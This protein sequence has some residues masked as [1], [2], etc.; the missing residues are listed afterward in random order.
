MDLRQ[1][2]PLAIT[3]GVRI[4]IVGV[5]H[6]LPPQRRCTACPQVAFDAGT[7]PILDEVEPV[8]IQ[9]M[10][11][12]LVGVADSSAADDVAA[13]QFVR[14]HLGVVEPS[15]S[16]GDASVVVT[17]GYARCCQTDPRAAHVDVTDATPLP[18][19][20]LILKAPWKDS[21]A[22]LFEVGSRRGAVDDEGQFLSER[23]LRGEVDSE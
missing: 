3:S 21:R 6:A 19:R 20:Q 9:L 14:R 1:Q 7:V 5:L 15:P 16:P 12:C 10:R 11:S 18:G 2:Q 8:V 22:L 17:D 23:A 4:A 13:A